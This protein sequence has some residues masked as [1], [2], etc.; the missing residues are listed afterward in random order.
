MSRPAGARSTAELDAVIE[1]TLKD[2]ELAHEHP[3]PGK[4]LV[5]LPGTKKLKTV[6]G[7]I[8]GEQGPITTLQVVVTDIEAAHALL[9]ERGIDCSPIDDQPWG[10][11]V[12]F[13]D[14]DGN[15]WAVQQTTPRSA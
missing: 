12:Y 10:S 15:A 13:T 5:D 7:L 2:G 3:E 14:P 11:F 6:C 8:V 9:T 1:A 4:W